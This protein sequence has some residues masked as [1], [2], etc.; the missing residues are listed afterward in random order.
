MID[1]EEIEGLARQLYWNKDE[2]KSYKAAG[3]LMDAIKLLAES[4]NEIQKDLQWIK[5]KL[6]DEI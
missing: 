4:Q 6:S 1:I 3:I 2:G 5:R